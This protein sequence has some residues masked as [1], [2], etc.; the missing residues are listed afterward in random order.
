M[1][2]DERQPTVTSPGLKTMIL[3]HRAMLRDLDRIAR[4]AT[5]LAGAP[6]PDLPGT[7]VRLRDVGHHRRRRVAGLADQDPLQRRAR[8]DHPV[9]KRLRGAV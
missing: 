2:D 8:P 7:G 3:A 6:D 9:V 4:T 5:A 1:T